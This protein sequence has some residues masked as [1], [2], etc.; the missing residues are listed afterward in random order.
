MGTK[1]SI[2]TVI[3]AL[4]VGLEKETLDENLEVYE[5]L[6]TLYNEN[7]KQF[8]DWVEIGYDDFDTLV[9]SVIDLPDQ[10]NK[11]ILQFVTNGT[12]E[13]F[14]RTRIEKLEGSSCC[15]DKSSFIKEMTLKALKEGKN[16]S[17]YNDY[18]NVD[19]IKEEKER[20]AY[21][22]PKSVSDTDQAMELFWKWYQLSDY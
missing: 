13:H 19:S 17:L 22:S 14:H 20:Q 2:Q 4:L 6:K 10:K 3:E 7:Q 5:K 8:F 9:A 12:Y 16:L 21:W 1:A 18:R 15:A 11:Y